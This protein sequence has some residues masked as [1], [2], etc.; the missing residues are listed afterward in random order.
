ML[1]LLSQIQLLVH[2]SQIMKH[3]KRSHESLGCR[4]VHK[5][6]MNKIIN[7]KTLQ[8]QDN[9][10][11]IT[12][13]NFRIRLIDKIFVKSLLSVKTETLAKEK[14]QKQKQTNKHKQNKTKRSNIPFLA[15]FFLHDRLFAEQMLC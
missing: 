15:S 10:A 2:S 11:K 14:N 12:A 1:Y 4:R 13:Q 3:F 9:T 8:L 6:E 5:V 7:S